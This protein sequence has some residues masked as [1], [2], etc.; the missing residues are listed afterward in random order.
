MSG[1]KEKIDEDILA[2]IAESRELLE[3]IEPLLVTLNQRHSD[4]DSVAP[5]AINMV[6][7]AFHT[8]KG[9]AAFYQ[10]D[11]VVGV[12][13][14]A[15][16]LLEYFRSGKAEIDVSTIDLLCHTCDVVEKLFQMIEM[17]A[18][19]T[20]DEELVMSISSKLNGLFKLY[21]GRHSEEQEESLE[22]TEMKE[23]EVKK[24]PG[25]NT[26]IFLSEAR[27]VLDVIRSVGKKADKPD[28]E[29]NK[30]DP[31][32]ILGL[33][34]KISIVAETAGFL[35][36]Y[37]IEVILK[38]F[39]NLLNTVEKNDCRYTKNELKQYLFSIE[40]T[41]HILNKIEEY[42]ID[43]G[44]EE[45][46]KIITNSAADTDG[47]LK[48]TNTVV[49]DAIN[50]S[51]D[52]DEIHYEKKI[53]DFTISPQ[54]RDTFY[55]ESIEQID[56][57]EDM[58][59]K[60]REDVTDEGVLGETFRLLHSFKGSCGFMNYS[61]L[62]ELT[63]KTETLLEAALDGILI[64]DDWDL[65]AVWFVIGVM[66][67]TLE[68]INSGE[69]GKIL[70]IAVLIYMLEYITSFND[71]DDKYAEMLLPEMK[72]PR[73]DEL[74]LT[75]PSESDHNPVKQEIIDQTLID[76]LLQESD[77]SK[78]ESSKQEKK[79][80][81]EDAKS[82]NKKEP[83]IDILQDINSE[84]VGFRKTV[85]RDI[86]VNLSKLD[87]LI[88]LIGELVIAENMVIK[89]PDVVNKDMENFEKASIHLSKIVRD[90]QD[91]A[92][93]IRMIP[94]SG[95]FRKM[96]RLVH[97][98]SAKTN[99]KIGLKIKGEDT[100]ID[101]T[102]A[103]LIAD[104]LVHLIRNSIDHGIQKRNGSK[105][106][107]D[108][109]KITLEA[110]HEG[111]EV[112]VV[113]SDD[114]NGLDVDKILQ[115]GIENGLVKDGGKDLSEQ[116]IIELIFQPGFSTSR[117]VTAVSGRGVG[118]DVVK[119]NI[120]K[121]KGHIDVYSK[122]GRGTTF[123][124]RIPL[125][126][127]IID[128]MLVRVGQASYTIP[129]LSIRESIQVEVENVTI[130]MDGQE[131]VK[132]RDELIPVIRL[133]QLYNLNPDYYELHEGLLVIIEH[134]RETAC[135]FIDEIVGEQQTVIKGLSGYMENVKGVSGCTI[136]GD[137]EV[138]LILDVGG[139][140]KR[141]INER[142]LVSDSVVS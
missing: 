119:K 30:I 73:P 108:D 93:S 33:G 100:E 101:K 110:R 136:L 69:K 86:R 54:M 5:E 75:G 47:A 138:S 139:L 44:F 25:E 95:V 129:L 40:T 80:K 12:T 127:A 122:P 117:I 7:R 112:W 28:N 113:V 111:G 126:L 65:K 102:V 46:I 68:S 79:K 107:Q 106:D 20:E 133:H 137:G 72:K 74:D 128:G 48:V 141:T 99:K 4:A 34:E 31:E 85:R 131:I 78:T 142:E 96:I 105:K 82:G 89:N 140:I 115:K 109:G 23:A 1:N 60:L 9:T 94:I 114:G 61:N 64:L 81:S 104:P 120:E 19:D 16:T 26:R 116:E 62:E 27:F 53:E 15:E 123:V 84:L 29:N 135:L 42:S 39:V 58:L 18:V 17:T 41:E 118:M 90:L 55:N 8:I 10:F 91:V 11:N 37:N 125:T 76:T 49:K 35:Q 51:L 83:P 103:E 134:Q 52:D 2:F 6:F 67:Q 57:I 43:S 77:V 32:T 21:E 22:L 130:T 63:H 38:E 132:V 92:L 24:A 3:E 98:L 56:Y 121:I 66:R 88:N 14:K 13:H 36:F 124:M 71:E 50:I 59:L 97:D 45:Q 87:E 70:N